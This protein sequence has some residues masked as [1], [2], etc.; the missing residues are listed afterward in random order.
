VQKISE[1]QHGI[2]ILSSADA[3]SVSDLNND[4]VKILPIR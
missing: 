3:L 2:A 4:K 1:K